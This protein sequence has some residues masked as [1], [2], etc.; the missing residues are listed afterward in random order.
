MDNKTPE[1]LTPEACAARIFEMSGA[2]LEPAVAADLWSK[3]INHKWLLSEK[4][5]R[6]VGLRTA[7]IEFF[8]KTWR[9][10]RMSTGRISTRI[11]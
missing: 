1:I 3:I 6:D 4:V 9:K 2:E 10:P 5:G 11:S 7:C 8:W